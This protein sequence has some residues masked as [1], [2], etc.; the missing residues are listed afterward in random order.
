MV[1]AERRR[2]PPPWEVHEATESFCIR[3][4]N[5]QALAH[6][7]FEDEKDRRDEW[8]EYTNS[9]PRIIGDW[10]GAELLAAYSTCSLLR[11]NPFM[12]CAKSRRSS[13][14]IT[15]P[16]LSRLDKRYNARNVSASI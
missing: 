16:S 7:Y 2:F 4:A 10:L 14:V 3:D 15:P 5:G 12:R 6:V 8:L 11:S 13:A 1:H 9:E